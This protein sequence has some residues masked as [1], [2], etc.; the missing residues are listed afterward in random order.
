MFVHLDQ[1]WGTSEYHHA[2]YDSVVV[3]ML[4]RLVGIKLYS[5]VRDNN[6]ARLALSFKY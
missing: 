4:K 2:V 6:L 1:E 5:F 3:T